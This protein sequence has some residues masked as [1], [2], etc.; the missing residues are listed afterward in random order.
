MELLVAECVFTGI[1]AA[2]TGTRTYVFETVV[3][4]TCTNLDQHQPA[5]YVTV[6]MEEVRIVSPETPFIYFVFRLI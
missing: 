5:G 6:E 2:A 3:G 4:S 1:V